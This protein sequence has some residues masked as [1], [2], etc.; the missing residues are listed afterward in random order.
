[1]LNKSLGDGHKLF[2]QPDIHLCFERVVFFLR[3]MFKF[4][5]RTQFLEEYANSKETVLLHDNGFVLLQF[6][7]DLNSSSMLGSH[8]NLLVDWKAEWNPQVAGHLL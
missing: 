3:N 7:G 2:H 4:L 6:P 1:M 5:G 8:R